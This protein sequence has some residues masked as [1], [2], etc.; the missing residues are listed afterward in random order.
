MLSIPSFLLTTEEFCDD[1]N[2]KGKF[3]QYKIEELKQKLLNTEEKLKETEEKKSRYFRE[4]MTLSN[5]K[6]ILF[7]LVYSGFASYF[8]IYD[9]K[10]EFDKPVETSFK[11]I[12]KEFKIQ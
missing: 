5:G 9:L 12:L 1:D 2:L 3:Q 8:Y 10:N 4:K 6:I 7:F 11:K